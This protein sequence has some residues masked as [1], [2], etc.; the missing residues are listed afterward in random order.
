V[1]A[2]NVE[3]HRRALEAVNARDIE[4]L[5]EYLDPSIEYHSSIAGSLF[6]GHD[7]MRNWHRDLE[8]VWGDEFR[9]EPEAYFDLGERTLAFFVTRGRGSQS[10]AEVAMPQAQAARWRDGLAV[11]LKVYGHREEALRDLGVSEDEVEP[12]AP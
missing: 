6:R 9:V 1:S 4:A 5:I 11:Y 10:G 12:I 8:D 7:G 3:L 2:Q